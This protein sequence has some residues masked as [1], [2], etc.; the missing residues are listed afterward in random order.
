[1]AHFRA[2][3][4][5]SRGEASRLGG[6]ESGVTVEAQS[7]EGKVVTRLWHDEKSGLDMAEVSLAKHQGAGEDWLVWRGPVN[8]QTLAPQ[9]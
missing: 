6:K 5:G 9:R 7:W 3:I 2:I 8:G 4:Q 1:M